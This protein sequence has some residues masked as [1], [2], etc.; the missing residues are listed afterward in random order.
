[1]VGDSLHSHLTRREGWDVAIDLSLKR[2]SAPLLV[3]LHPVAIRYSNRAEGLDEAMSVFVE[4]GWVKSARRLH[5]LAPR[6]LIR[7]LARPQAEGPN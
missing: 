7:C 2:T 5:L 1:M 3:L 4:V 6:C